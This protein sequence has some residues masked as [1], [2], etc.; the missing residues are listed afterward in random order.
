MKATRT[1]AVCLICISLAVNRVTAFESAVSQDSNSVPL[2]LQ[3]LR[4][5]GAGGKNRERW[6]DEIVRWQTRHENGLRRRPVVS[7][8][9]ARGLTAAEQRDAIVMADCLYQ[10]L[11][12]APLMLR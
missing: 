9:T 10:S 5:R 4:K 3:P 11:H 1:G 7:A 12:C 2:S 8:P 6:R